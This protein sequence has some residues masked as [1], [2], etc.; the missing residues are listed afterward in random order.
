MAKVPK[1]LPQ[2]SDRLFL[3]DGGLETT[4]IFHEGIDLPHFAS[5][6]LLRAERHARIRDY[7]AR[8]I[9]MAKKHGLGFI[10]EAPPGAPIRIGRRSSAI[11][12][13]QLAQANRGAVALMAELRRASRRRKRRW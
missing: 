8:Y 12:S 7:Y 6:D 9:A 5:F 3:T 13:K 11:R 10:L 1:Q 2:L 4:L